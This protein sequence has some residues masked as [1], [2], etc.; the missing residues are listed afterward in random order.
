MNHEKQERNGAGVPTEVRTAA[1]SI[2]EPGS[3]VVTLNNGDVAI[4]ELIKI[5]EDSVDKTVADG[6][7]Q[8]LS[9]Q[10]GQRDV[11]I[12]EESNKDHAAIEIFN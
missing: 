11:R 2:Q 7:R 4:V 6:M 12:L 8:W 9:R 10:A 5:H 1:F 3:D